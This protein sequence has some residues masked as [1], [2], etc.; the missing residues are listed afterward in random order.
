MKQSRNIILA[1]RGERLSLSR[2]HVQRYQ[3]AE[4]LA[5][6]QPSELRDPEHKVRGREFLE[7]ETGLAASVTQLIMRR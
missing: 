2:S 6:K 5:A 3:D 7:P 4:F 1:P